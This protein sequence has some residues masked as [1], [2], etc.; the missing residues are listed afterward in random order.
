MKKILLYTVRIIAIAI[1]AMFVWRVIFAQNKSTLS[2]IVATDAL[3]A[4]YAENGQVELLTHDV[5][6]EIS[7]K[8]YFSA[9]AF[10]YS[11]ETS[12][13]E[14]TVRYNNSTV[15][16]LGDVEFRL[17]TVDSS[18][19][20][21]ATNASGGDAGV[22][23]N[24]GRTYQGHPAG[25]DIFPRVADKTKKFFYNYERLVFE[26]VEIGENT[27]VIVTICRA[28][29][30]KDDQSYEAAVTAHFAEQPMEKYKLSSGERALLEGGK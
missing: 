3:R 2:K 28:D 22:D 13:V 25:D 29:T 1:C 9:Y 24:G 20:K 8:G 17:F 19:G 15:E 27:N 30:A 23:E 12:E 5:A 18:S 21:G 16:A 11:P 7:E 6:D 4:A 26:G 14:V 10:V